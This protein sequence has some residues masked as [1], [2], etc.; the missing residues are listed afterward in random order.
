M[1]EASPL[2]LATNPA[3]GIPDPVEP[4]M[5]PQVINVPVRPPR[6][7]LMVRDA[8]PH[9]TRPQGA[10]HVNVE[11]TAQ[12]EGAESPDLDQLIPGTKKD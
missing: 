12:L 8:G 3:M 2:M 4:R 9:P 6:H 10:A 5:G 7:L 1:D 11:T